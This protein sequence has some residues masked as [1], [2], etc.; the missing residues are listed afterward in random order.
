MV[1]LTVE[2]AFGSYNLPVLIVCLEQDGC[3]GPYKRDRSLEVQSR[4]G[5]NAGPVRTESGHDVFVRSNGTI[6]ES[7][8]GIRPCRNIKVAATV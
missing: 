3:L 6:N 1:Y 2:E 7:I 4:L 8:F 5:S